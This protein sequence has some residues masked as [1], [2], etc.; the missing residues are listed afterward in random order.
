MKEAVSHT[1]SER[2][3]RNTEMAFFAVFL[4]LFLFTVLIVFFGSTRF[5]FQ[6]FVLFTCTAVFLLFSTV[7]FGAIGKYGELL[8]KYDRFI[9]L[10]LL[11]M[12]FI[13][14]MYFGSRLRFESAYDFAAVYKGAVQ[15]AETGGFPEYQEY[16]HYFPNNLGAMAFLFLFFKAGQFCGIT[17][18]FMIGVFV[19]SMLILLT[20]LCAYRICKRTIGAAGGFYCLYFFM[21]S[22]PFYFMGAAFYTDSLSMLFPVLFY[23]LFLQLRGSSHVKRKLLYFAMAA[24]ICVGA[25][26]KYT[27][28]IMA[29]AVLIGLLLAGKL[30]QA[31]ITFSCICVSFLLLTAFFQSYLFQYHLDREQARR[32]NTP[33]THWIMMGLNRNTGG[34]Y[35]PE[36]Y[37]FTR[38]FEGPAERD[39][40]IR[41]EIG[42]RLR[43][44]SFAEKAEFYSK[45]I[46]VAFGDG[47]Y[48]ISDFLDDSPA[49]PGKIHDYLLYD[50]VNYMRY[51]YATQPALISAYVFVLLGAAAALRR[52]KGYDIVPF[53][54]VFG[55][56]LFLLF[57]ESSSRYFLNFVPVIFLCA[58]QGASYKAAK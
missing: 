16:F 17:D 8:V 28:L 55:V 29:V 43:S 41:K 33:V 45:K 26:I 54:A 35:S 30:R 40:A 6:P 21:A 4:F 51:K 47:T 9:L 42:N 56:F 13:L 23:D 52:G 14:Q 10:G 20:I 3:R 7:V 1:L 58:A 32:M 36:D 44:G 15:W 18:Y 39:A 22:L 50:G 46:E 19:N 31:C 2:I 11:G 37:T 57:W 12:L 34:A 5:E 24:V 53:I 48:A 49:A 27:V 25:M 38:S